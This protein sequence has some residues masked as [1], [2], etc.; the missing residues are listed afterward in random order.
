MPAGGT[1]AKPTALQ[2][3][4]GSGFW[5]SNNGLKKLDLVK[6]YITA[7]YDPAVAT[8]IISEANSPTAVV[9]P[10]APDIKNKLL[11]YASTDLNANVDFAVMPDTVVPGSV[12]NPMIRQTSLAFAKG[13]DAQTI[14]QG[15]ESA[16]AQ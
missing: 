3:W 13:T 12:A 11:S 5:I 7:W 9:L 8:R 4:T 16:S 6:Q 1:Y 10:G 2:G 14:C 15:M